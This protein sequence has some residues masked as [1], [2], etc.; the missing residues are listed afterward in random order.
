[1]TD[2]KG[3]YQRPTTTTYISDTFQGH[4][5]R[6]TPSTEPGTDYGC[7]YGSSIFAPE[8]GVVVDVKATISG[9]TGRYVTIDFNDGQRGRALHLSQVL[10]S[11][12]QK[13]KR[14]Q[15]VA[16]SGASANGKEWGVGAH[17]HQT[18]WARHAYTFGRDATIDFERYVGPDNDGLALAFSQTVADRQSF[19]NVAQGEKLV[20]DGLAGPLYGAA[21]GRYQTYLKGRGWYSGNIDKDWGPLTQA[22]HE[23]RLAEWSK[24]HA[25][26]SPAFHKV[27]LDDIASIGNVEG[28]QKIAR[29]YL[30]QS[31]DNRWGPKSK[32]GLQR[33]LDQNHGGSLVAWLRQRWGYVG[34]DQ[35]G[36]VMKAALQ[37]ANAANRAAL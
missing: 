36:P 34:N 15:L 19:L 27:T 24:P 14:G 1:M 7:A 26:P 30:A 35:F 33:F 37:R 10:V 21:V 5:N 20:V 11:V 13:V 18:L 28:L 9:A 2:V 6:Q 16:K 22:G 3:G 32:Q 12:G 25:A 29:L 8:D 23:K 31:V 4:R 17:V